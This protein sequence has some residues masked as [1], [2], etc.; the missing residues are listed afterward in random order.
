MKEKQKYILFVL[1]LILLGR[2][3]FAQSTKKIFGYVYDSS[4][5][6]PLVGANVIIEGSGIGTSTNE[7][8]YFH[9]DNLL[10]G[11]YSV[12]VSF[13][14]YKSKTEADII[15]N[16]DQPKEVY[17]YLTKAENKLDEIVITSKNN[18]GLSSVKILDSEKIDKS[19]SQSVAEI[20]KQVSG[21]EIE[22]TGGIGSAKRISIRGSNT[23]QVLVLLD[24][25]P[26]NN[27]SSANADLS[28]IP[29]N[30]VEKIEIYEGGSSSKFGSG[31]IGGAIN[32]ITK[33]NFKNE[34]K[35]NLSGGTYGYFNVEPG[36]SGNYK[37]LSFY[38]SY[39]SL[40]SKNNYNYNTLNT[41]G[42]QII[43]QR[44]NA[45][46]KT[47]NFFSRLN[48]KYNNYFVSL[49]AQQFISNRG[50]PGKTKALTAYAR[51]KNNSVILS[52]HAKATF[53]NLIVELNGSY[54]NNITNNTN[55]YPDNAPLKYRR[56]SRY[57]YQYRSNVEI[58]NTTIYYTPFKWMN[59]IAG[60]N[61][62][63]LNY[64]DKNFLPS[65]N[66]S[67]NKA[68][69][70]SNGLF[71]HQEYKIKLP[72]PFNKITF[73]PSVRY[74]E[75]RISS[76]K[77]KRFEHQ[78][79][80]SLSLY[81]SAGKKYQVFFKSS[82]SRS[83]RIPTFSD[84]FYQD[85]RIEGKPDLLPEKS[86]NKEI[87]LGWQFNNFG[88]LKA[89]ATYY[90]Y[91]IEDMI[92]WKLGSFEVFRPFNND[93]EITGQNYSLNYKF[94]N[95]NLSF[96]AGYTYLQPLDKNNHQTTHNKIIPYRPQHSFKSSIQF[97]YKNFT[98]KIDY[99]FV[100]KRYVT[101]ANT[102]SLPSY[103]V[104][105]LTLLQKIDF[106]KLKTTL[107]FSVNNLANEHYEIIRGYPIPGREFRIGI[108]LNYL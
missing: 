68:K 35:L 81:L 91:T 104:I 12:T 19:N 7:N 64:S 10:N 79:S 36:I 71:V 38:L 106:E 22:S 44:I 101:I 59:I 86:L 32:I 20:L 40:Q 90:N 4:G 84:L 58:L 63:L 87:G 83:F 107:I 51:S 39:N 15:V 61:G 45:D 28:K 108:K 73:S 13:I 75:M 95:K 34:Y 47:R 17:F 100:S 53:D 48:Y 103:Q 67:T 5:N 92:V 72:E 25:I 37:N 18:S 21:L 33:R 88:E 23:N 42:K 52:T 85:V 57:D 26:L 16:G 82:I 76:R 97:G 96:T 1:V 56:Y 69:D 41:T 98:S 89:E 74:D 6:V 78:W 14:G 49:N 27:Q 60:Y 8:G 24:G 70:I 77:L 9:F 94:P 93:A 50:I 30:I 102:V 80:P 43:E 54:S 46:I 105:D 99:R 65:L 66:P 2:N 31:A 3:T 62:K 11:T 29:T 55:M